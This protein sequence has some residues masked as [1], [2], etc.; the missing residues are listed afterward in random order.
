[1]FLMQMFQYF[2]RRPTGCSAVANLASEVSFSPNP[3]EV[4][5]AVLK[6]INQLFA[7]CIS[8]GDA[9]KSFVQT[10][11][12]TAAT[13]PKPGVKFHIDSNTWNEEDV[14]DA[15]REPPYEPERAWAVYG[16]S[17]TQGEQ[18]VWKL[19][20][21]KKPAFTVNS[22]LPNANFGAPLSPENQKRSTAAWIT[23]I[24]DG[25]FDELKNIPPRE[26]FSISRQMLTHCNI[27]PILSS[28]IP[29]SLSSS[30]SAVCLRT[31]P[32]LTIRMRT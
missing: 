4:I 6:S 30:C 28:Q 5:P 19:M 18:E 25:K 8:Q 22:V 27:A 16:A 29:F 32:V 14:Q 7:A 17:K 31:H 11:S 3:N 26:S 9:I 15:W 23:S 13:K 21:D 10:S 2:M 24:M 12:S 1:M 20:R